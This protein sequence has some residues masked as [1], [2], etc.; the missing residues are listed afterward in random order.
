MVTQRRFSIGSAED[1]IALV[2]WGDDGKP[3][4]LLLHGTGFCADVWDEVARDLA[5]DY[6][7]IGVDRRGHGESH[8]PAADRYHFWD[9]AED[10]C[11]IID[12]LGLRNIYGI[13]HSAGAT[14]LL[15]ATKLRPKSF[16]RLFVMEP[17]IMDARAVR[18][19]K[20]SE[21]GNVAVY[22]VLRR[23]AEFDSFDAAFAR[24]RAAPAF[25]DWT[26]HSLRTFI[27]SGFIPIENGRVRLR[28]MP[29]TESAVLRPIIET[30]EQ[31]YV[32][33]NRG[34]PF[35]W[36]TEIG[37]PVRLTTSEKSWQMYKDMAA[38]ALSL[39]PDVSELQFDGF[40]HCV[41]QEA[42]QLVLKALRDF[43]GRPASLGR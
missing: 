4:A 29:E 36:L 10:V 15:L 21:W 25:A 19:A 9:Y 43:D 27:R 1:R 35:P 40:G 33:D 28:C 5:A 20:L 16:T 32:G 39:I 14:D 6:R 8:T 3:P 17:T 24:F 41:V 7:V 42:P 23:Q 11:R 12:A 37:C 31:I 13:G 38:R 30:M 34:N 18:D 2:Q 26:E 22:G